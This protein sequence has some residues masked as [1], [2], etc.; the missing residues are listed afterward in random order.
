MCLDLSLERP[1]SVVLLLI[2]SFVLIYAVNT[3]SCNTT[4]PLKD[5]QK[6]NEYQKQLMAKKRTAKKEEEARLQA[7]EEGRR[8]EDEAR[9]VKKREDTRLRVQACR[10]RKREANEAMAASASASNE[11]ATVAAAARTV[12]ISPRVSCR[13]FLFAVSHFLL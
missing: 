2:S 7:E 4:M 6:R 9:R 10:K 8:Q 13:F 1:N 3:F 5:T 11:A 12:S